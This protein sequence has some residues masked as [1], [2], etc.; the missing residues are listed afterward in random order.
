MVGV[1]IVSN[2]FIPRGSLLKLHV[3]LVDAVVDLK[4]KLVWCNKDRMADRYSAG[5]QFIELNEKGKK[6]LSHFLGKVFETQP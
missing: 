1:K 2:T 4:A 3:N 6:S 5:L